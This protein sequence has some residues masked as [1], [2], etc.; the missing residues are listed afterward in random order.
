MVPCLIG[1]LFGLQ[2]ECKKAQ[3]KE[4]MLPVNAARGRAATLRASY[5]ELLLLSAAAAAS[6][7]ASSSASSASVTSNTLARW[8]R[9][10]GSPQVAIRATERTYGN[11]N[12]RSRQQHRCF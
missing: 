4:V 10:H 1:F 2:V 8:R 7:S 12:V 3:P 5:G 9:A 11:N 6:S